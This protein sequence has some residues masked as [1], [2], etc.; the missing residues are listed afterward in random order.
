[1]I[2]GLILYFWGVACLLLKDLG[3]HLQ[4]ALY[5]HFSSKHIFSMHKCDL[6]KSDESQNVL[7]AVETAHVTMSLHEHCHRRIKKC[8]CSVDI[9]VLETQFF[10][11]QFL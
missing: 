5:L 6:I 3:K 2:T 8:R 11:C 10:F 9:F 4:R 7:T 1:M